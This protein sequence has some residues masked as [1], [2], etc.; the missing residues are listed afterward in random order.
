MSCGSPSYNAS[1]GRQSEP[2]CNN[3]DLYVE[4]KGNGCQALDDAS[5]AS[6]PVLLLHMIHED[7]IKKNWDNLKNRLKTFISWAVAMSPQIR[8]IEFRSDSRHASLPSLLP[9][10]VRVADC[11]EVYD[12]V[13]GYSKEIFLEAPRVIICGGV[14]EKILYPCHDMLRNGLVKNI[15]IV[16]QLCGNSGR[17][18]ELS[19]AHTI[20]HLEEVLGVTVLGSIKAAMHW[21]LPDI[22]HKDVRP[23]SPEGNAG[24]D[25]IEFTVQSSDETVL[26]D[27][28]KEVMSLLFPDNVFAVKLIKLGKGWSAAMKFIVKPIVEEQGTKTDGATT[29]IKLGDEGEIEEELEIT[30]HMMQLLGNFCPQVL[31]YAE[32]G[33]TAALHLS[34]ADLGNAS[35]KGFADLYA[36]LIS[37]EKRI[38]GTP[39]ADKL[40]YRLESCIDF[41]FGTLVKKL[42]NSK[43]ST[44]SEVSVLDE[45][46][47]AKDLD[48]GG[49]GLDANNK[50]SSGWVLE[51][52]WRK[53]PGNG[54]LAGSVRIHMIEIFGEEAVRGSVVKF[55]HLTLPNIFPFLL[56]NTAQMEHLRT[57]SKFALQQ[58]F[59][60]GDLHGDNIMV[61]LKDNRFL[62]DFGKTGLGHCLE[63]VTWLESF[64]LLSY[65]DLVDE[66]EFADALDLVCVLA[67]PTGLYASSCTEEELQRQLMRSRQ[68]RGRLESLQ[69]R[70]ATMW[71]IVRRIRSHLGLTL[72]EVQVGNASILASLLLLRNSLFFMSARENRLSPRRRKLSLAFACAYARSVTAMCW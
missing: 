29:F 41:V 16:P 47:L 14:L 59:V 30:Q 49:T 56:D 68:E 67:P 46:G 69:P 54:T 15:G 35:P 6:C 60:H 44:I 32:L 53:K 36:Q 51:K 1:C 19:R 2:C 5:L 66:D 22:P 33:E 13:Q 52:L 27:L 23:S 24:H 48:G 70:V 7:Q 65:T 3:V 71:L 17:S 55:L 11:I 20:S 58:C 45:L 62:I 31:G 61:D 18:G 42:H 72:A 50:L 8:I 12:I 9:D 37:S 64:V 34:L 63:D 21:L 28:Q 40:V 39:E 25:M 38:V 26:E 4:K 43:S 57:F 10:K